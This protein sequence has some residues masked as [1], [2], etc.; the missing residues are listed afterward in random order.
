MKALIL[1]IFLVMATTPAAA[2]Y[3]LYFVGGWDWVRTEYADGTI[4]TPASE[5]YTVQLLFGPEGEFVR[6]VNEI[7]I[8]TSAWHVAYVWIGVYHVATLRT[9]LGD[10][11]FP[12]IGYADYPEGLTLYLYD[13]VELP[14]EATPPPSETEVFLYRGP[15]PASS[16][17]WGALKSLFR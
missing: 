14:G 4:E 2:Q 17:S 16:Q 15:V 8:A 1:L 7:E 10:A 3:D 12:D 13:S 6:Y 5:G 11:W 9:D